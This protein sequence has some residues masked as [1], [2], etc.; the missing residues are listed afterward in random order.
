MSIPLLVNSDCCPQFLCQALMDRI[1]GRY[2]LKL[3]E[4]FIY[5][6]IASTAISCSFSEHGLAMTPIIAATQQRR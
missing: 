3:R 6:Q 2:P 5:A 4:N 1:S